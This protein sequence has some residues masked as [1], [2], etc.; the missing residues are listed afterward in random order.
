MWLQELL[1]D[2]ALRQ[3]FAS[4]VAD[5]KELAR[6]SIACGTTDYGEGA[7]FRRDLKVAFNAFETWQTDAVIQQVE[8][9]A[10]GRVIRSTY[11]TPSDDEGAGSD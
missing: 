7:A 10:L 4:F 2:G 9:E 3:L 5:D 1:H 11:W 8:E 6:A